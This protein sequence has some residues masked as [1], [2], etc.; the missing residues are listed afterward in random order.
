MFF[1]QY[2]EFIS[3]NNSIK[4]DLISSKKKL[5][6]M[7]T[8]NNEVPISTQP[9]LVNF[10]SDCLDNI[11]I[12]IQHWIRILH[13]QFGWTHDFDK[14]IIDYSI[15]FFILDTF[16]SS[17]K[18]LTTLVGHTDRVYSIDYSTF[19]GNNL[20]C[21]GSDD[22]TI[23]VWNTETNKQIQLFNGHSDYVSCV[24]FSPY[25]Y[26]YHC[27]NVICSSSWDNTFR[28]WDVKDNQQSKIFKGRDFGIYCF[29]FSPFNGSRY[30][31]CGSDYTISLFD[32]ET[33]KS[34]HTFKGHGRNV[35][36]V[37][38]SPL[39]GSNNIGVIGGNGYT[40]CSGSDDNTIRIWDIET[41]K[42]LIE[43]DWHESAVWSVKYGS[44]ELG[45]IGGANTILSGSGDFSACLWDIRSG[46][47]IQ[48]FKGHTGGVMA[49]EYSPFVI[50]N[51]SD[52]SNVICSGSF[53]STIRFWDIRSN[54]KELYMI[55]G[56]NEEDFGIFS[57]QFVQL[58]EKRIINDDC[59]DINLYYGL[60]NGSIR[61]WG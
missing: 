9:V 53:D 20:L 19:D 35:W 47:Q 4:I 7:I 61:I 8:L 38:F 52:Y 11:Q 24:R 18:L 22:N 40:I 1:I 46:E 12:I 45:N 29:E 28:C 41:A 49:V 21:S 16:C 32:V 56:S 6:K 54:K 57:L 27:R 34:L 30:L 51:S 42:Q 33:F 26:H 13:I 43:F 14:F 37:D 10:I 36:C 23:R 55:K 15:P 31:C 39:Q 25:H 60:G 3:K 44:N 5:K 17:S 59:C 50:K 48:V 2:F 58:E